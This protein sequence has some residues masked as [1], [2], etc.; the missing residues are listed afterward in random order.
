VNLESVA[1]YSILLYGPPGTGKTTV[2]RALALRL[3]RSKFL[4]IDG[5]FISRTSDFYQ[6]IFHV[7][8]GAK[9]NAPSLVFID[10]CDTIFEDK[11]EFAA[12]SCG[13]R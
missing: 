8:E 6:K 9:E 2:G 7:F 11:D 5:T 4:R 1:P 12:S 13:W 3:I 10:D